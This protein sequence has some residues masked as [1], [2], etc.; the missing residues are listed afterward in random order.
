MA[1]TCRPRRCNR[2]RELGARH[3]RNR[4]RSNR[5]RESRRHRSEF[6]GTSLARQ[7]RVPQEGRQHAC[8]EQHSARLYGRAHGGPVQRLPA[9]SPPQPPSERP[10]TSAHCA[11]RTAMSPHAETIQAAYESFRSVFC[12]QSAFRATPNRLSFEHVR[13]YESNLP[14]SSGTAAVAVRVS[15][16]AGSR[17]APDFHC[18]TGRHDV[19]G[20]GAARRASR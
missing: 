2:N 8:G 4:R 14:R 5:D 6:R 18:G 16:G 11:A 10:A 20:N 19:R 12:R 1:D 3:S 15:P 13:T 17:L 9:S 7:G